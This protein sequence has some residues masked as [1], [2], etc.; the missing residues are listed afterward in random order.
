MHDIDRTREHYWDYSSLF[1]MLG[2]TFFVAC[3]LFDTLYYCEYVDLFMVFAGIAGVLSATSD[4]DRMEGVWNFISCHM[5]LLEAYSMLRRQRQDIDEMGENYDGYY[6]FL[7]SRMCFLGGCLLD[8]S[9]FDSI[10]YLFLLCYLVCIYICS[11]YV[12]VIIF[13]ADCRV[14]HRAESVGIR[15]VGCILRFD[16]V[17]A[18]DVV[19]NYRYLR[20][21]VFSRTRGWGGEGCG[22]TFSFIGVSL[23]TSR[24]QCPEEAEEVAWVE[25][26]TFLSSV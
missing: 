25:R 23:G 26:P 2:G 12:Y 8:V 16:I 21:A 11:K 24:C 14:L 15:L 6:F 18:V 13:M 3:G 19:C 9:C 1:C 7:F 20:G 22:K 10:I 17:F 5:Y 4:S